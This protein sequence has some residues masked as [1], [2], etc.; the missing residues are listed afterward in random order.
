MSLFDTMGDMDENIVTKNENPIW[1]LDLD[2]K[3]ND[4]N[5][6]KWLN[7]ELHR[8]RRISRTRVY[9]IK[10][11]QKLYKGVALD[12]AH[13]TAYGSDTAIRSAR[14]QKKI[15]VNHLYDLV[16]QAVSKV[17]KYKP[18]VAMLPTN[19]EFEDKQAAKLSKRLYDHIAYVQKLDDKVRQSVRTCKI[20]GEGYMF[21]EWCED[22][23][24]DHPAHKDRS[25]KIP[26]LDEQGNPMHDE[27]SGKKKY[28]ER[29][30]K[31]GDVSL[32]P[33]S[34][35]HVFLDHKKCREDAAYCFRLDFQDIHEVRAD[36]PE[37][38]HKIKFH[39]DDNAEELTHINDEDRGNEIPVIT[40][41]HKPTKYLDNGR[42]IKFT[43]TALLENK[44]YIYSHGELPFEV[45]P[46]IQPEEDM[47]ARSFF[48]NTRMLAAQINNMTTMA[49]R[50]IKICSSPKWFMPKGSVKT[51]DLN[52]ST[53]IVQYKG[54]VAPILAQ[55]NPTPKEVFAFRQE[56]KEDM[57]QISGNHGISRGEPPTGVKAGVAMQFLA[58]MENERMNSFVASFNDFVRNIANKIV[59]VAADYYDE[60][61]ERA[62]TVYGG[63][64]EYSR[65]PFDVKALARPIDVRIQN[66]SALP[67]SKAQRIQTVI[68]LSERFPEL[69]STEQVADMIDFG[70]AN[71]YYSEATA[72]TRAA[73]HENEMMIDGD[74]VEAQE[75][76][77]HMQHWKVHVTEIQKP[78]YKF[79]PKEVQDLLKEHVLTHE[80]HMD[81]MS[82]KN[83]TYL[84]RLMILPQFPLFWVP[85]QMA[86]QP[87]QEPTLDPMMEPGATQDAIRKDE[88]DAEVEAKADQMVGEEFASQ[89][90]Q[91]QEP[92][93]II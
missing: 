79:L 33:Y 5:V 28:I 56:I 65:V 57:Q 22:L 50:N 9:E 1:A 26:L 85:D 40:F 75:W 66:S 69:V 78:G 88:I 25:E 27:V 8:L 42:Y 59:S 16:E 3:S 87:S 43:P 12:R 44:E 2:D 86:P 83:P 62:I 46:D 23:G 72:A 91:M 31:I 93:P 13:R 74:K 90:D 73:E 61:D 18:N 67:E 81:T 11:H 92:N 68:D 77:Y 53:S 36:Y 4:D 15:I 58:E 21:I 64:D 41:F 49:M 14:V 7:Q 24:P 30:V 10:R 47:Y 55:A 52:N 6:L 82:R 63:N 48:I 32:T 80:M 71:K 29:T 89:V 17:S 39:K 76:E 37:M 38:A 34:G 84:E 60:S 70:Q 35:E 54:P 19:D 45:L 20:A 51:S